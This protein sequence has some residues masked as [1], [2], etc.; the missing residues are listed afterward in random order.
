MRIVRC[1]PALALA[2]VLAARPAS[3][4]VWDRHF[5][6]P[7]HPHVSVEADD[8][9]VTITTW[10]R[11]EVAVHVESRGW[12]LGTQLRLEALQEGPEVHV[13]ARTPRGFISFGINNTL[14]IDVSM[15]RFGDQVAIFDLAKDQRLLRS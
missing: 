7:S 11:H 3:A 12:H 15:P 10:D 2:L 5:D 1:W 4:E 13:L 6:V 14:R 8:G 9:N